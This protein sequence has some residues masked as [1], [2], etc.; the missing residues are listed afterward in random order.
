[1]HTV[2]WSSTVGEGHRYWAFPCHEIALLA[3]QFP[4]PQHDPADRFLA[5][6][7]QVMNLTLVTAD[8]NL[9]RM[10]TVRTMKT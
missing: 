2:P 1:M 6:T 5:A 10:E 4:L 3:Q 9:L 7:A 8:D